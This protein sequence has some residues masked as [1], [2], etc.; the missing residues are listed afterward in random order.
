METAEPI[1]QEKLPWHFFKQV[2]WF[3]F[4]QKCAEPR[5]RKI[6]KIISHCWSP[7]RI[8]NYSRREN[9]KIHLN[10][11]SN[12]T[13]YFLTMMKTTTFHFSRNFCSHFI[14]HHSTVHWLIQSYFVKQNCTRRFGDVSLRRFFSRKNYIWY[15]FL[16]KITV[17]KLHSKGSG[18]MTNWLQAFSD[19]FGNVDL[20][21]PSFTKNFACEDHFFILWIT[22]SFPEN[23]K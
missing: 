5:N 11:C 14:F 15:K 20:E 13:F 10:N 21:Q 3:K 8:Q 1:I 6:E 2:N 17:D 9:S 18:I 22:V 16:Q 4:Q 12:L 23:G 7:L 19:L